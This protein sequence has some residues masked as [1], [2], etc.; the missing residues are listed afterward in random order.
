MVLALICGGCLPARDDFLHD[1]ESAEEH[2]PAAPSEDID[3][4]ERQSDEQHLPAE[5]PDDSVSD[6][7]ASA[8]DSAPALP[9]LESLLDDMHLP[10]D[11]AA[12]PPSVEDIAN[13]LR[14]IA[15][16]GALPTRDNQATDN[17][18]ADNQ[19]ADNQVIDRQ[20]RRARVPFDLETFQP[21]LSQSRLHSPRTS[22]D[23][24]VRRG[25]FSGYE[26]PNRFHLGEDGTTLV[27]G[28]TN[29]GRDRTELRHNSN[30]SVMGEEKRLSARLRFDRPSALEGRSRLHVVQIFSTGQTRGPMVLV[31]WSG[32]RNR[33]RLQAYVRGSTTHDLGRRPRGYFDLDI[34]LEEGVLRIYIDNQLKVEDDVSRYA[35]SRAYFKT[36]AYHRGIEPHA[37]EFERL[38]I[39]VDAGKEDDTDDATEV[40]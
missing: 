4:V 29:R 16:L 11:F 2:L 17:Q 6:E 22:G 8:E 19:V 25:R 30:W 12:A 13:D 10:A 39:T 7:R 38:T 33:D 26:L 36:G 31:S 27:M 14:S 5:L 18:V 32:D 23:I 37:V 35:A 24:A 28:T 20:A 21:V 15:H 9:T 1:F 34:R 3:S 40:E